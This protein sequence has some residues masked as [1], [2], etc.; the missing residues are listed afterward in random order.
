MGSN[1][2][3]T[4]GVMAQEVASALQ[5]MRDEEY[6]LREAHKEVQRCEED[7]EKMRA[8]FNEAR[9]AMFQEYPELAPAP[10]VAAGPTPEAPEVQP[11][12]V[13]TPQ[14]GVAFRERSDNPFEE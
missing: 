5:N 1:M 7:L 13:M 4:F 3:K 9:D 11:A 10:V 8:I 6:N 2:N 12:P 14:G